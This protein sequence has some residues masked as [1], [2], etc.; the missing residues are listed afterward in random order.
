[1]NR[2][3]LEHY[4]SLEPITF[5]GKNY[6]SIIKPLCDY[7]LLLEKALELACEYIAEV[8]CPRDITDT[9]VE[10]ECIIGPGM[11][12]KNSREC[13]EKYYLSQAKAGGRP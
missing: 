3:P 10:F 12:G 6:Q 2:P 8:D 11:C 5:I 9:D 1:M 4:L 13:W 7:A